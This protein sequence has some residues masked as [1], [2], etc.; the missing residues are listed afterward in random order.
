MVW[1]VNRFRRPDKRFVRNVHVRQVL[2]I[3]GRRRALIQK[4]RL[5]VLRRLGRR[6]AYFSAISERGAWVGVGGCGAVCGSRS[7]SGRVSWEGCHGGRGGC[8][9]LEAER[10][11]GTRDDFKS[12]RD[13]AESST[14]HFLSGA[15]G[16]MKVR[17]VYEREGGREREE[18]NAVNRRRGTTL[19]K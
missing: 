4:D 7:A 17:K 5:G 18:Q 13:K 16:D 10:V 9:P 15:C 14:Q 11:R 19:L 3:I 8:L 2:H 1:G 6:R 12:S